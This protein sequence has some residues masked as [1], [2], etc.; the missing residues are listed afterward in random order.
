MTAKQ[1]ELSKR[2]VCKWF[3]NERR[4][5]N[6]GKIEKNSSVREEIGMQSIEEYLLYLLIC[7]YT[8]LICMSLSYMCTWV[9]VAKALLISP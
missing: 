3:T 7:T 5:V 8:E 9:W 4:K 2:Q 6:C 1:L